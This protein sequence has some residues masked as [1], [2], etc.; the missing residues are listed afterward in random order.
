VNVSEPAEGGPGE[1]EAGLKRM[2]SKT[3]SAQR[4]RPKFLLQGGFRWSISLGTRTYT[5]DHRATEK[6]PLSTLYPIPV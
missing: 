1:K 2:L 5:V 4:C 6:G 3:T